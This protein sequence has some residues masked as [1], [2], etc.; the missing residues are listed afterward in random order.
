MLNLRVTHSASASVAVLRVLS[1]MALA[2]DMTVNAGAGDE[3]NPI[4]Q[5]R[6]VARAQR[7][8]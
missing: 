4:R 5:R 2:D 7:F 3:G 1:Y 6:L 8:A